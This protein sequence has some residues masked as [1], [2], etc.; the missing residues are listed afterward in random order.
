MDLDAFNQLT[1]KYP[2]LVTYFSHDQCNV[3]KVLHPKIREIVQAHPKTHF[4]YINTKESTVVSGQFSVFAVPT[5]IIFTNGSETKR[6]SRYLDS[7]DLAHY[8]KRISEI[9]DG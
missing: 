4:E 6:Y 2:L 7:E 1:I 3:C 9:M 5:I 8:L